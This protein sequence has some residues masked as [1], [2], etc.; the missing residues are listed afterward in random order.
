[1]VNKVNE[2]TE[3]IKS[4][5]T[6]I[7]SRG[8]LVHA[9]FNVVSGHKALITLIRKN[10]DF[11]PF[12]AISSLKGEIGGNSVTSIVSNDGQ[13]WMSGMPDRGEMHVQ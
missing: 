3:I 10:G 8:A 5:L 6:L 1:D 11:V 4:D 13:V 2:E 12:G 9:K 7:P